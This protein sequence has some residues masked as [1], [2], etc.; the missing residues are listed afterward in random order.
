MNLLHCIFQQAGKAI[1]AKQD[2]GISEAEE[3]ELET[4]LAIGWYS[5]EYR[6]AHGARIRR[7]FKECLQNGQSIWC[8]NL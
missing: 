8:H 7:H 4:R 5:G 2:S 3:L 1:F 6:V